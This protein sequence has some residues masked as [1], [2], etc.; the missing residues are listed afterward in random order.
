[1]FISIQHYLDLQ[2]KINYIFTFQ[3]LQSKIQNKT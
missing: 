2:G 3:T 1:M